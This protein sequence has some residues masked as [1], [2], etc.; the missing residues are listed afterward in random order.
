MIRILLLDCPDGLF[1]KLKDQG[2]DVESGAIGF[3][4]GTRQLPSQVYESQIVIY[5]P[6]YLGSTSDAE[7]QPKDIKDWTPE[8]SLEHLT[9]TIEYGATLLIFVN[10][11]SNNLANQNAAYSWIPYMPP[12][13]FTKDKVIGANLFTD[14]PYHKAKF[15]APIT[16]KDDLEIPVLQKLQTPKPEYPYTVFPLLW[17]AHGE[18]IGVW[19]TRGRGSLIVLPKF[20]SNGEIIETFLHRVLPEMYD[21]KT[22][23][24][25]IDK[26][27]SPQEQRSLGAIDNDERLRNEIEARLT[28]NRIA[29]GTA[30]REKANV[31]NTDA[32]AKQVLIYHDTA[33]RQGDVA[34]FYLYKIVEVI[35]N[36][37][38]GEAEAIK[39]LEC[40]TEWKHIK[41]SANES[42]G[43]M[44]HAPKP[45]DVIK[46]W[47]FEDIKKC[48]Q[49]TEKIILAYFAT[50]FPVTEAQQLSSGAAQQKITG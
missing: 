25:L 28:A 37:H 42:Y 30:R 8:F 23:V 24:G 16:T 29:L 13:A 32:T 31:I 45:G 39:V 9:E 36:K 22:R 15:L 40:G 12:I 44:R 4:T 10:R 1:Y 17:N 47:T 5:S 14:Y 34:L 2:F 48:F 35:E 20:K 49:D 27:E 43:D 33:L 21:L 7:L 46:R 18:V 11:L 38:G 26:Y 41:R 6:T 3:Q 19:M 50:L